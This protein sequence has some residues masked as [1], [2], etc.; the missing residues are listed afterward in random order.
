MLKSL[1]LRLSSLQVTAALKPIASGIGGG[2]NSLFSGLL[3][4]SAGS[5]LVAAPGSI[6]PFA[7][8]GVIGAPTYFP[9]M[10]GGTGTE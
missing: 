2:L 10:N 5:G 6:K 3:G 9:L 1:A 4:G 8:G 7:A